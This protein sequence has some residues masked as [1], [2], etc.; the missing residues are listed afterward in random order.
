M[1]ACGSSKTAAP[2]SGAAATT[3]AAPSATT[4][5]AATTAAAGVDQAALQALINKVFQK[6]T[7][8]ADLDPLIVEALGRATGT[9]TAA[10]LDTALTCWKGSD[11]KVPGGGDLT[12]AIT[13]AFG[14]NTWRR[15][16]KMET[17]LQALTYPQI[18]RILSSDANFDLPTFQSQVRGAVAQGANL[19]VGYNDFGDAMAPTFKDAQKAGAF[20]S[21]YVGPSPA[22]G[23]DAIVTQIVTDTCTAGTS[24]ADT[25]IKLTSGTGKLAFFNGTPG[26]PQG[27]S[28]NKCALDELAKAGPNVKK[29]F[30]ADT[31]WTP[32]GA[33]Q[34]ASAL[35]ATGDPVNAILYDYAD[36]LPGV[37]DTFS[38]AGK[39]PPALITWTMNNEL[40]HVWEQAQ[41]T[42]HA[43][44]LYYTNGL[45]WVA[46]V[47]V[48]A[49]MNAKLGH[50]AKAVINY[51]LPFVPAKAGMYD[52]SK[53]GDFPATAIVPADLL[54]KMI[55]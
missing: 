8:P 26:N 45:N 55:G 2:S 14:G 20:V 31:S 34:A 35:I 44:E 25:A 9:L 41:G 4:A 39:K 54:S 46:R 13:D 3:T 27:A 38:Q 18:G 50:P 24:M 47:S 6:D 51:P 33:A 48:T 49:V 36:P 12:L 40:F 43:F 32:A 15:I 1:A 29:T 5:G 10:Q 17:V 23:A 42:D 22:A 21:I 37:I 19:I 30:S 11:C 53:P 16:S 28:W 7:N 52:A